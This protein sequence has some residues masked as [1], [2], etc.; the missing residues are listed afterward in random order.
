MA[1]KSGSVTVKKNGGEGE[2]GRM[3]LRGSYSPTSGVR[4]ELDRMFNRFFPEGWP[5]MSMGNLMDFDPFRGVGGFEAGNVL[6]S[7]RADVS[8]T[9]SEYEV[10]VELP[11]ID[12]KDVELDVSEG[13]LTLRAEKREEREEKKKNYHLTERSY[14]NVRR[15]FRVPEGV[16]VGRIKAD[17]SKGV[18]RV[19]LPKTREAKAK[20]RKI[21]VKVS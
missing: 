7:A 6:Q 17:F 10:S 16:E 11:G 9:D 2:R 3:A 21:P 20:Q 12:E 1:A 8:E 5:H 13:M 15:S 19:M 4:G 18:L 14:G